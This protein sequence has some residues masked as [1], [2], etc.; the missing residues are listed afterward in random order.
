MGVQI[1]DGE[2]KKSATNDDK[3]FLVL[4][5]LDQLVTQDVTLCM[6]TTLTQFQFYRS[7]KTNKCMQTT[8]CTTKSYYLWQVGEQ[9]LYKDID[10]L[11]KLPTLL[12]EI[13]VVELE[14]GITKKKAKWVEHDESIMASWKSLSLN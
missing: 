7:R 6:L 10:W 13:L 2:C 14:G 11:Q 5:C 12:Q 8:L 3:G 9:D 4:N 1:L